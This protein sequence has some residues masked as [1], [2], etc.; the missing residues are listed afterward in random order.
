MRSLPYLLLAALAIAACAS[1]APEDDYQLDYR[2]AIGLDGVADVTLSVSQT[3]GQLKRLRLNNH[4]NTLTDFEGSL[5]RI[6]SKQYLWQVPR[7]GGTVTWRAQVPTTPQ[8]SGIKAAI[9]PTWGLFRIETMLPGLA[10]VTRP[11]A[12]S[13]TTLTI[14]PPASWQ[15]LTP[16]PSDGQ[17]SHFIVDDRDRRFD[18]PDGWILIGDIGVRR[19][20]I[21]ATKV[22]VA[23]PKGLEAR[24]LDVMAFANWHLPRVRRLFADFPDRLLI[25]MADDPFFRGGLSA[26]NS[27]FLH[28]DR[29]M[30]SGNGTS[31][32]L[33]ELFHVGLS[34]SAA[35]GDDWIVEG[36]AEYY[37]LVWLYRT[38]TVTERRHLGTLSQLREWA[39]SADTLRTSRASGATTALAVGVFDEL[40]KEI[41]KR[42]ANEKSLDDVVRLLGER[43]DTLDLSAL[44]EAAML[45]C[46]EIPDALKDEHLPGY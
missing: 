35:D 39:A 37:S 11:G 24:R 8:S 20:T 14:E 29:P 18:R 33:H 30:I 31:T 42:T 5:E 46:G 13:R 26:P 23:A 25:V 7:S 45:V 15:V 10:S 28:V 32:F 38:G 2:V 40:D 6:D 34:R 22:A 19:D 36:L 17:D 43:E 9:M 16:Y 41:S 1:A 21:A 12:E 3:D 4:D 44:R 27:L